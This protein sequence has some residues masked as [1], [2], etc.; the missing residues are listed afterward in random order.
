[1][2]AA[3]HMKKSVFELGGSDPLIVLPDADVD[4]AVD[5]AIWSRLNNSG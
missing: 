2:I 3:K 1:M 5:V 4:K